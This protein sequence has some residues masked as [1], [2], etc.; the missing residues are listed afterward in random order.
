M[1]KSTAH[2]SQGCSTGFKSIGK[3][4]FPSSLLGEKVMKK[5]QLK[6][7]SWNMLWGGTRLENVQV[8]IYVL[9]NKCMWE[10]IKYYKKNH[11]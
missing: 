5:V 9:W 4:F 1:N 7:E 3:L 11:Q 10:N 6:L 2:F 8:L